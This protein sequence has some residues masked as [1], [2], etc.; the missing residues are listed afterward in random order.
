MAPQQ[1]LLEVADLLPLLPLRR[2]EEPLPQ[3]R[4]LA[5]GPGPV[6]AGPGL[7]QARCSG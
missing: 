2:A 1:E 4:H 5:V 7:F 3:I 6:D